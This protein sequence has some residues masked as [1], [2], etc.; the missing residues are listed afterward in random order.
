MT[1]RFKKLIQTLARGPQKSE[2]Y[3]YT[4]GYEQIQPQYLAPC[5][6]LTFEPLMPDT[7]SMLSA[8]REASAVAGLAEI[9]RSNGFCMAAMYEGAPVGHAACLL[10]ESDY[11]GFH[12]RNSG[13]IYYCHVVEAF[14]GREIYPRMLAQIMQEAHRRTQIDTFSVS[15]DLDNT[16]S[17]RGIEK[18]GFMNKT[19]YA[20]WNWW[21]VRWAGVTV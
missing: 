10:P 16:A 12:I 17:Q 6:G 5:P 15:V 9:T 4:I 18:V 19:R 13:Y 2:G 21:R 1:E 8:F 11:Y 3:Y 14:R 7:V 20:T